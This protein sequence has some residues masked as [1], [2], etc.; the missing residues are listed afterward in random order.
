[1]YLIYY[2]NLFYYYSLSSFNNLCSH[3]KLQSY[4]AIKLN[5]TEIIEINL[6]DIQLICENHNLVLIISFGVRWLER[7]MGSNESLGN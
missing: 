4:D 5:I 1:M 2:L 7:K 3:I 6:K